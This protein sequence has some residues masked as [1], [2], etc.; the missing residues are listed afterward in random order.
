M[1]AFRYQSRVRMAGGQVL[2]AALVLAIVGITASALLGEHGVAHLV[3]LRGERRTLGDAAFS[4]LEQN[5]RL[6]EEIVRLRTDDVYLEGLARRQLG[7][8]RPNE[9][10]YRFR[11]PRS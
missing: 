6:R 3:R 11:R 8:V 9:L 5:R 7:L 2:S 10:V 1:M 4:L